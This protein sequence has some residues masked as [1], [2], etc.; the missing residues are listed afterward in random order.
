M[1]DQGKAAQLLCGLQELLW[2]R[3][4][5]RNSFLVLA[6]RGV[7]SAGKL[8]QEKHI[9]AQ[10]PAAR[11]L[12]KLP[13]GPSWLWPLLG[14]RIVGGSQGAEGNWGGGEIF[15]GGRGENQAGERA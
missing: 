9:W 8:V 2:A 13:E 10:L 12:G 3:R 1:R 14:S 7:A 15:W 5:Q 11:C 6:A 4:G